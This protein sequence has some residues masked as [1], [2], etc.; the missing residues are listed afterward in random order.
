MMA[1]K[2]T[3][4]VQ[5]ASARYGKRSGWKGRGCCSDLLG[6]VLGLTEF[7]CVP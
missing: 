3:R 7:C 4:D 2:A 1:Q 5:S 6:S